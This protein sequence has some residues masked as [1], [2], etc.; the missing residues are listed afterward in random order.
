VQAVDIPEA[1][2]AVRREGFVWPKDLYNPRSVP[3]SL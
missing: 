2:R 3:V 1:L